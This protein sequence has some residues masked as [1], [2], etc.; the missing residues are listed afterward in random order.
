M[1][2]TPITAF[3][4]YDLIAMADGQVVL[5][6]TV[7]RSALNLYGHA[8]GGY[9]FTLADQASGMAVISTGAN[10]VT[11]QSSINYLKGAQLGDTLT[12]TAQISHNGRSSKVV[13]V[14]IT[15]QDQTL[16]TKGT[17]T[18]FVTGQRAD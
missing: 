8:H 10:A 3:D 1:K 14:T 11:I 13:D 6:T 9:L 4:N 5:T 7:T 15:N 12:I 17:F 2:I 16:L 18:M